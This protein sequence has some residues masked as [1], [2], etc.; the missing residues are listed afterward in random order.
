M[1]E[2]WPWNRM[3][4]NQIS[5]KEG[6]CGWAETWWTNSSWGGK[7]SGAFT[8]SFMLA[9]NSASSS[10]SLSSDRSHIL[11][12]SEPRMSH[13]ILISGGP[14]HACTRRKSRW[15][16]L[17]SI[18]C[19]MKWLPGLMIHAGSIQLMWWDVCDI[20]SERQQH[21]PAHQSQ[22]GRSKLG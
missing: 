13:I 8:W 17:T 7:F 4:K 12:I 6:I 18:D 2:A 15:K 21:L 20:Q 14:V 22:K 10:S 1:T 5:K 19:L 3:L 9:L 16:N 11:E